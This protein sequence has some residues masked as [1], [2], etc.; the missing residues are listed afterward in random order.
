MKLLWILWCLT[1]LLVPV[2]GQGFPCGFS[3]LCHA[4][5]AGNL[6]KVQQLLEDGADVNEKND[7]NDSPLCLAAKNC[8]VKIAQLLLKHH[9]SIETDQG[10][11]MRNTPLRLAVS[12]DCI[13]VA[14]VLLAHGADP[15]YSDFNGLATP[16]DLIHSVSMAETFVHQGVDPWGTQPDGTPYRLRIGSRWHKKEEAREVQKY[17]QKEMTQLNLLKHT[18]GSWKSWASF[19]GGLAVA[20]ALLMYDERWQK[21]SYQQVPAK[22]D[23]QDGAE[24]LAAKAVTPSCTTCRLLYR[25]VEMG[26]NVLFPFGLCMVVIWW[27]YVLLMFAVMFVAPSICKLGWTKTIQTPPLMVAATNPTEILLA[28][29][30]CI[31]LAGTTYYVM[32]LT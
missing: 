27:P 26:A 23:F 3:A 13:G 5:D 15:A 10:R 17:W 20:A 1:A 8:Q 21:G 28:C 32:S 14:Q 16:L 19:F 25:M 30:R 31:A 12:Y 11:G 22:D 24:L 29:L 18:A 4:V 7:N 2:G 9:A 6:S